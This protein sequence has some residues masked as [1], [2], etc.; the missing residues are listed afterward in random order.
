[1]LSHVAQVEVRLAPPPRPRCCPCHCGAPAAPARP[2][3]RACIT[4][5]LAPLLAPSPAQ[6]LPAARHPSPPPPP[7]SHPPT[8][9]AMPLSPPPP[10][11][12]GAGGAV[13][14]G[15]GA[16]PGDDGCAAGG[17]HRLGEE[18]R[19]HLDTGLIHGRQALPAG[20]ARCVCCGCVCVW[21]GGAVC[22]C[23]YVCVCQWAG[24]RADA[25]ALA[26]GGRV[27]S[28]RHPPCRPPAPPP[29]SAGQGAP[30]YY[31]A[32]RPAEPHVGSTICLD[33]TYLLDTGELEMGGGGGGQHRATPA[34]CAS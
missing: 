18:P 23:V 28:P 24:A 16:G 17:R 25:G 6:L 19:L 8:H 7:S 27:V 32:R 33:K 29:P 22:M 2:V 4:Q 5:L 3:R 21:G 11:L 15:P 26:H 14:S 34:C 1:M 9:R 13:A 10:P 12:P 30:V 20:C 31:Q